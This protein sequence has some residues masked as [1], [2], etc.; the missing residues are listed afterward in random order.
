MTEK[1]RIGSYSI[2]GTQFQ[3]AL[4]V[5]DKN[6]DQDDN[7]ATGTSD[8]SILRGGAGINHNRPLELSVLI[9]RQND[10]T[11]SVD[12]TEAQEIDNYT[13]INSLNWQSM[14]NFSATLG[15]PDSPVPG[16]YDSDIPYYLG[17]PNSNSFVNTVLSARGIDFRDHLPIG[18]SASDFP[19]HMDLLD[20]SGNSTFT[21]F[22]NGDDTTVFHKR[23]GMTTY[24]WNGSRFLI[25]MRICGLRIRM[26][27]RE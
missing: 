12:W 24:C 20:G 2:A 13:E 1:L 4:F 8:V 15:A 14:W 18:T 5:Y 23:G 27:L 22:V 25:L 9:E 11:D 3:H 6:T 19:G 10:V 26:M 7:I 16:V 17:G 21:A